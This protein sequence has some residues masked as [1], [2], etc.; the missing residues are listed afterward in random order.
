MG[1]RMIFNGYTCNAQMHQ[2]EEIELIKVHMC[3]ELLSR[4]VRGTESHN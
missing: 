4:V 2:Q 3:N 1:R